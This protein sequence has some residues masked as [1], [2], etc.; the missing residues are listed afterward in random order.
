MYALGV[1]LPSVEVKLGQSGN[2]HF[3]EGFTG[4]DGARHSRS[5]SRPFLVDNVGNI[6]FEGGDPNNSICI[7]F[8]IYGVRNDE[9][10]FPEKGDSAFIR[11]SS[12]ADG[13][14][15]T[16]E[17]SE[18]QNYIGFATGLEAPTD[19]SGYT[20]CKFKEEI[21]QLE[22]ALDEIIAIQEALIGGASE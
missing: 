2:I 4:E 6:Q 18:G 9:Y 20:W 13:T 17:W 10:H 3:A 8:Q 14:N 11:Y 12:N 7:P 19:K 5:Y 15:F 22:Q 16:E 1:I 21:S